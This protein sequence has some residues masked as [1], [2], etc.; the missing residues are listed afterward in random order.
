MNINTVKYLITVC[1]QKA[2]KSMNVYKRFTK[3]VMLKFTI[4]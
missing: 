4:N 2:V 1:R 3:R